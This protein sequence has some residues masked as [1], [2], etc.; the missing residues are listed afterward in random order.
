MHEYDLCNLSY[1][2]Y[3]HIDNYTFEKVINK[4][5]DKDYLFIPIN[6]NIVCYPKNKKIKINLN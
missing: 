6:E 4:L 2:P 5:L 1:L 3:E